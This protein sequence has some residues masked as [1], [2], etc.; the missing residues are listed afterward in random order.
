MKI[1]VAPTGIELATGPRWIMLSKATL[2][3]KNKLE[4]AQFRLRTLEEEC[5][6]QLNK[7]SVLK[8]TEAEVK[9]AIRLIS[10]AENTA[11]QKLKEAQ[12][13]A[14]HEH[15]LLL[16]TQAQ[17]LGKIDECSD[18]LEKAYEEYSKEFLGK[19]EEELVS[20]VA[21]MKDTA[22]KAVP[23]CD[24]KTKAEELAALKK[25]VAELRKELSS[26]DED[27][28]LKQK[29]DKSEDEKTREVTRLKIKAD[30]DQ[31]IS[32]TLPDLASACREQVIRFID[33]ASS[34]GLNTTCPDCQESASDAVKRWFDL[35]M[36]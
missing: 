9:E 26:I 14:N 22:D 33:Q 32:T 18:E 21:K 19:R 15:E 20:E 13:A 4:E 34:T 29:Q 1:L 3:L 24:P 12:D 35:W 17:A 30:M 8:G 2:P 11:R 5:R 16:Q 27:I 36:Q 23:E 10:Q 6:S 31:L 7:V 28:K 25:R